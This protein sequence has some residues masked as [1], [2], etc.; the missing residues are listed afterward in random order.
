MRKELT[1]EQKQYIKEHPEESAYAITKKLQRPANTVYY[2]YHKIHGDAKFEKR[3]QVQKYRAKVITELY[4]T[5]SST[6]V[7]KLLGIS[8]STV[9]GYARRLGIRHTEETAK[10]LSRR[11]R[12]Y[13][14][15]ED[16]KAKRLN[17]V[18]EMVRK[19][20]RRFELGIA[21]HTKRKFGAI[22]VRQLSLRRYI[23]RQYNY[24]YD[25]SL[26][27]YLTLFY[28]SE[29]KRLPLEREKRYHDEYGIIFKNAEI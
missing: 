24:F 4:P 13:S 8:A 5:H 9:I 2:W 12:E 27:Q 19:E 18:R 3:K 26:K 7:A 10:A 16:V 17:A 1:E 25:K 6:E 15:T 22:S 23:E 28:D 14:Q 21:Q 29:T 20:K 11:F